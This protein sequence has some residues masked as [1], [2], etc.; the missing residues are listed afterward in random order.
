M[1]RCCWAYHKGRPETLTEGKLSLSLLSNHAVT[2]GLTAFVFK[3]SVQCGSYV[4]L[5]PRLHS[6]PHC[7]I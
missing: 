7:G 4:F 5:P 6:C 1:I 3:Q 2:G